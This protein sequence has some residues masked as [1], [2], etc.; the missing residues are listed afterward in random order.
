MFVHKKMMGK[1]TSLPATKAPEKAVRPTKCDKPT[2]MPLLKNESP[3]KEMN[4]E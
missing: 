1:R 4:E 2:D 3:R